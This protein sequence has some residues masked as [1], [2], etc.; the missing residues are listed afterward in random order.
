VRRIIPKLRNF[1]IFFCASFGILFYLTAA[2]NDV[3]SIF[4][5]ERVNC[6]RELLFLR[7]GILP[8]REL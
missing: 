1:S 7:A 3:L 6:Q 4:F 2:R 5:F 8:Q